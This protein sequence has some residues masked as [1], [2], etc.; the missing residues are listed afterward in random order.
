MFTPPPS[1]SIDRI[2]MSSPLAWP[3][4]QAGRYF[5]CVEA[6]GCSIA[7]SCGPDKW[8]TF[9]PD[10]LFLPLVSMAC[11]LSTVIVELGE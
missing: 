5:C 10:P 2:Y 9:F 8:I 3:T 7:E 6:A 11:L 4:Y 1:P